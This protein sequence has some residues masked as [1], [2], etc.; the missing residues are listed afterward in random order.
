MNLSKL[1][2]FLYQAVYLDIAQGRQLDEIGE[3][4]GIK[5]NVIDDLIETDVSIRQRI[6]GEFEKMKVRVTSLEELD[7]KFGTQDPHADHE[8]I[9][10]YAGGKAFKY[11]R[12]C[13]VEVL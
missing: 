8:V 2:A 5:R 9:E 10:N 11:C 6:M 3:L 13:K 12:H 1:D 7:A 4:Y